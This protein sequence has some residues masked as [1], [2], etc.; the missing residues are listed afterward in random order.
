MAVRSGMAGGDGTIGLRVETLERLGRMWLAL[1]ALGLMLL[2]AMSAQAGWRAVAAHGGST[3]P[4]PP[5]AAGYEREDH[6]PGAALLYLEQPSIE[7]SLAAPGAGATGTITLPALPVGA[8]F[9][10]GET[11]VVAARPF[12]LAGVSAQDRG[13]ALQ[14]LTAAIYYEAAS[15]PD[16]GQAA[17]A[18]VVLNRVRHPV[19]PGTVCGVVYQGSEHSGCQFSFA[20]DGAMARVPSPAA[21]TRA[22]RAAA[23]ALGGRV[24]AGV[25]L[26]THYHT[27]AVTP[28]W[29]RQLVMTDV[30]GA[31]FFHRW[32]GYWGTARAFSR[33]YLGGEPV[34]GPH[35]PVPVAVTFAAVDAVVPVPVVPVPALADAP[36]PNPVAA[37]PVVPTDNL[38]PASTVLDRWKNSGQPLR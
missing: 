17:V 16:A 23:L 6:F 25:G 35:A 36:S 33:V 15:E 9:D 4:V 19:F 14:C 5:I 27:F 18:Q 21:W 38:P 22:A 2:A 37:V 13:R 26:A 28:A 32:S 3:D 1:V 10:P 11:G 24:F 12:S 20:C 7:A 34:P 31:H 29:N 8:R 30:V